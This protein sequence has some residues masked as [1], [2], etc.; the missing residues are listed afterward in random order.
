MGPTV[1]NMFSNVK[2]S[3]ISETLLTFQFEQLEIEYGGSKLANNDFYD[4]L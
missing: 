3:V 1:V 4:F 2:L